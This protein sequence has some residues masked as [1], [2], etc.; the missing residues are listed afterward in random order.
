MAASSEDLPALGKPTSP[1]SAT[2]LRVRRIVTCARGAQ[3]GMLRLMEGGI[4][5]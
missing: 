3:H 5:R 2:S 1:M 4:R